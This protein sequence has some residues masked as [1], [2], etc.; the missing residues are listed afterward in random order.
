MAESITLQTSDSNVQASD[1]LGRLSFA[2]SNESNTLD[3]RLIGASI[4]AEAE[5]DFTEISNPTAIVFST[6]NSE[7]ATGKLKINSSGHFIPLSNK[8]YDIGSA[9]LKFRNIYSESN[10]IDKVI[11][12]SGSAPS[13]TTNTLY[14]LSGILHYDTKAIALLPS[15]GLQNQILQKVS[16]A[17][18]D[19]QWTELSVKDITAGYDISV[20]NTSGIYTIASTNLVHSDSLQPQGFVNRTDSVI[21]V[22]NRT[23]TIAPTGTSYSYYNQGIKVTKTSSES[24]TIPNTTNI[25]Y[26]HFNVD[27]NALDYKTTAFDFETDIP[28]AFIAWNSGVS[29]SGQMSFFA[30]ERHGISMDSSTHKWIH[31][32]FGAQ[33]VNGLSIS[34]YSTSGNGSSNS[35]AT[36]AIGDGLLYQEDIEINITDSTSTEPFHQELSP[37]A[38]IPVYYHSGTTGQWVKNTATNYPVKYGAN[39]PQYNLLTDGNW[40]TP[41]VS[42]AGATRY[43]AV[44]ILATNQIDDPIISIMGQ[45]VDSNPG[46]AENNNAWSDV[47]L[48]N[49]PLNE[50]KPLYRLIFA[51]DSDF[52]NTPKCYLYSVLDL[53]STVIS[54]TVG[55]PQ[56]DHGSLFGLADDDHYQ[57][58]HIDT[59]RTISAN[60]TFS[61]GLTSNGLISSNSGNFTQ[62]LQV[63]GTGVSISG[64]T[65]TASAISDSTTAGRSLL[66]GADASAQRTSLGLGTIATLSSG[67]YALLSHTHTSSEITNFNTSVSGLLPVKNIVAGSNITVSS[68]SGTY[69]INSTGG[70]GGSTS[71]YS[72]TAASGFPASGLSSAIYLST[73]NGR[74]YQWNSSSYSE[75]GPIG[76]IDTSLWSLFTPPAPSALTAEIGNQQLALSWSAPTVLSQ[77]PITDYVVQYSSNSG[78]SW[79]TFNDGISTATSATVTGLSNGTPYLVR[80]AGINAVG[81]GT[82]ATSS[83]TPQPIATAQYLLVGG[84]G[85]GGGNTGGGGG[86]GQVSSGVVTFTA[87]VTYNVVIGSGG[88]GST[89]NGPNG[90]AS[91]LIGGSIS[92]SAAGG[93]GGGGLLT[94]PAGRAGASVTGGSGGGGGGAGTADGEGAASGGTGTYNGGNTGSSPTSCLR[95][96]GGG[97][98]S[99]SAGTN[100][101]S[102]TSGSGGNGTTSTITGSSVVYAGGGGGGSINGTAYGC[103][104]HTLGSAGSGGGGIGAL[105]GNGTAATAN[106]GSGGGGGGYTPGSTNSGGNG[107]T[108]VVIIR[109]VGASASSTTGSPTITQVGS[110]YVYKFTGAG[111][112]TL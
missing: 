9:S 11:L 16:N 53:R 91:T 73:D 64:H 37:I 18:Y 63:N 109:L 17:S 15:G 72:Y 19:L 88:I 86:A 46:T 93:G 68:L 102:Y 29:P 77:T 52:T 14:N 58:V 55:I 70:G 20:S 65:H 3:A 108:G 82:F 59:A 38:Q 87:G 61:N 5:G 8:T 78:T 60:H 57:Y 90:T 103:P 23:F 1:V 105:G 10:Y 24:V 35:D 107:G 85:A 42:P 71:L 44:W 41:D 81:S 22:S 95:T 74:M 31:Y 92:Q 30:E 62:S 27:T 79:S 110:D 94:T 32:T 89:G 98:G 39:G 40:T 34:N 106:T 112:I 6:A 33:Y 51:G 36:I 13:S 12:T 76:G 80:V 101:A 100:A 28:V 97:G 21:S 84:G 49:L 4:H 26:I 96:G 43:F 47:N 75:I 25:Y 2:A 56:N 48:T 45:R 83:G 7:S 69:T 104:T 67:T 54:S 99:S 50:I 111:S 66:T